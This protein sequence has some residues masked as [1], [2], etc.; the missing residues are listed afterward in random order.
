M[1]LDEDGAPL[2][3]A[4]IRAEKG[5]YPA[6]L[7]K[8]HKD[9]S[10]TIDNIFTGKWTVEFYDTSG[11]QAGLESMLVKTNETATLDFT[12]GEKPPPK[13][14]KIIINQ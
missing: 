13:H 2:A 6:V 10:Y 1:V 14:P 8:T 9:G 12:V 3:G 7:L 11:R 4:V 5:G